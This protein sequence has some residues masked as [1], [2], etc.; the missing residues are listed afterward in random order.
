MSSLSEA[1]I[2]SVA[3]ASGAVTHLG[4]AVCQI[5]HDVSSIKVEHAKENIDVALQLVNT[6]KVYVVID[7][8]GVRK[9]DKE[10]R[11]WGSSEEL[12]RK[13]GAIAILVASPVSQMIGSFF[14]GINRPPVPTKLFHQRAKAVAWLRE[15]ERE[16][17]E[18]YDESDLAETI[19]NRSDEVPAQHATTER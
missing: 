3:T 13:A 10:T 14:I 19:P 18:G 6:P 5:T 8:S 17:L 12:S 9:A 4:G 11:S 1:D 15:L 16:S 7:L 2:T